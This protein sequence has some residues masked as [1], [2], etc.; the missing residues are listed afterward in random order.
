MGKILRIADVYE[1]LTADRVYRPRAFTPDE[2]LR[3]MWSEIGTSF[4]SF[5]LKSFINMMGIYPVGSFVELDTGEIGL[6][7][8]YTDETD[9]SLPVIILLVDDGNGGLT[10]GET[11]NLACRDEDVNAPLRKIIMGIPPARL[12][13]QPAHFL[14]Q[15]AEPVQKMLP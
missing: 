15:T 1:A 2:A 14:L 3:R 6:V 4:D 5:L 12:G 13:V 11:L 8:E 9:R 7:I 10:R